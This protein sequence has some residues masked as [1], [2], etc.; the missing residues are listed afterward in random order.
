MAIQGF[1]HGKPPELDPKRTFTL[2]NVV[3]DTV[4][5]MNTVW[6]GVFMKE[7]L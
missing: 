7:S 1:G 6:N 3:S 2:E 4:L 5:L